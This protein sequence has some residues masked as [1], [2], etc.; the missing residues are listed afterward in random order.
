ML[1][2]NSGSQCSMP[3]YAPSL[4]A[5]ARQGRRAEGRDIVGAEQA[6]Q[7]EVS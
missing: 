1:L 7:P 3:A 5:S 4:T 2:R 6:D